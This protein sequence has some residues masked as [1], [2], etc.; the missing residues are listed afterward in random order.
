MTSS[1][2]DWRHCTTGWPAQAVKVVTLAI[3]SLI[4]KST[5]FSVK[6]SHALILPPVRLNAAGGGP[7][8]RAM[9]P[10]PAVLAAILA[11]DTVIYLRLMTTEAAWP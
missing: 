5:G 11:A 9:R 8:V 6:S 2:P 3:N 7:R 10:S 4:G 1:L